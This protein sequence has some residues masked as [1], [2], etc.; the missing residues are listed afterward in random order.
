[1][2]GRRCAALLTRP[3]MAAL[4]RIV[5]AELSCFS[6]LGEYNFE[7]GKMYYLDS[8]RRYLEPK[9]A[10]GAAKLDDTEAA[11]THFPAMISNYVFWPRMLLMNWSPFDASMAHAV[12]D[13]VLIKE[14]R[15]CIAS[16]TN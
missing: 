6:E 3:G 11:A 12:D 8:V 9:N 14:A 16:S 7:H 4:F 5:I 13:D 2:I 15:Y 10:L 1:M